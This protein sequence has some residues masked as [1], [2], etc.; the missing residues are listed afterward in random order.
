MLV[1]PNS[2]LFR[3]LNEDAE[4]PGTHH[5]DVWTPEQTYLAT[6]LEGHIR[7]MHCKYNFESQIHGGTCVSE[8]WMRCQI[9]E[10]HVVHF[11]G[12]NP[13]TLS[14]HHEIRC[15]EVKNYDTNMKKYRSLESDAYRKLATHR[16]EL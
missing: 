3:L 14:S 16:S 2:A 4:R 13:W 6:I 12:T 9:D 5:Q 11:S 1:N 7:H 10:V 8:D 15:V